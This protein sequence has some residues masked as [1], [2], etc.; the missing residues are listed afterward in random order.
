MKEKSEFH[1][2]RRLKYKVIYLIVNYHAIYLF[3]NLYDISIII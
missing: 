3:I 1:V 2:L